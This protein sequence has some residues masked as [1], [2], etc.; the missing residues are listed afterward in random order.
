M[1][2]GSG[3]FGCQLFLSASM[4][5]DRPLSIPF[6]RCFLMV[7]PRGFL[8]LRFCGGCALNLKLG[9]LL[10]GKLRLV[11]QHRLRQLTLNDAI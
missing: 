6:V 4:S 5:R 8:F 7:L 3:L 2:G 10:C 9:V 11:Q 1:R